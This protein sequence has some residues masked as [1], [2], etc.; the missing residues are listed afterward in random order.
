[1]NPYVSFGL[2]MCGIVVVALAVTA[3]MATVFNRRAKADLLAA[4]TPLAVIVDGEVDLE[5]ASAR[6]RFRGHIAEGRATNSTTGPGR[7]FLTSVID[8]AGGI[9]WSY[10]VSRPKPP[11]APF[12]TTATGFE[13]ESLGGL[14]HEVEEMATSLLPSPGWLKFAYDPASGYVQVTRPMATRRDIPTADAFRRH[15]DALV[16]LAAANRA[17]QHPEP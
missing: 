8:G 1:M 12:E 4:L 16:Q 14:E 7:V 3:Y 6:G 5:E 2:A 9:P 15:L 17:R 13:N 11:G 10:T